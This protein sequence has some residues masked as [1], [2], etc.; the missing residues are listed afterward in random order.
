MKLSD[1]E[2][3]IEQTQNS[4]QQIPRVSVCDAISVLLPIVKTLANNQGFKFWLSWGLNTL[5]GAL[6]AYQE[7]HCS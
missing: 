5:V 7:R 6:E 1:L 2:S 4:A 3:A